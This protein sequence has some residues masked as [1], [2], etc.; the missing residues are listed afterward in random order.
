LDSLFNNVKCII[1]DLDG[2]VYFGEALAENANEVILEIR[3]KFEK[4]FFV[5]NNSA[6]SRIEIYEK[7][8]KLGIDVHLNEIIN[9]GYVIAKYLHENNYQNVYCLGTD[10]LAKEIEKIGINS[11][12]DKPQ[13]VVLGYD[14]NFKI[15]DLEYVLKIFHGNCK[16]IIANKERVYPRNNGILSPGNG[17]IAAALEYT[18]NKNADVVVGKPNTLMLDLIIKDANLL[19]NEIVLVGDSYE[20][21]IVMAEKIGAKAVLISQQEYKNKDFKVIKKVKDITGLF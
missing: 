17:A 19:P 2:T 15:T 13:A 10:S 16:L 12:S 1:L 8:L 3:E 4:I 9:S 18:L 5:T 21:D 14:I 7:L 20:S 6:K 11:K